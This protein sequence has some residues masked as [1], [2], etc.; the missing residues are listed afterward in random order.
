M[1]TDPLSK[2]QYSTLL[3]ANKIQSQRVQCP[4]GIGHTGVP[5]EKGEYCPMFLPPTLQCGASSA[6]HNITFPQALICSKSTIKLSS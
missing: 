3:F 6:A 1:A 4:K 2:R 5:G